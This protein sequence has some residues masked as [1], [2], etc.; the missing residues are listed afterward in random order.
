MSIYFRT[1]WYFLAFQKPNGT[2]S[3]KSVEVV[4]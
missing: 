1:F 2:K 3:M 4:Q